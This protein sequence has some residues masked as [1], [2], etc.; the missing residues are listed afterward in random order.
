LETE[1][2]YESETQTEQGRYHEIVSNC[3]PVMLMQ[4]LE[5]QVYE[6]VY[7]LMILV[8][9]QSHQFIIPTYNAPFCD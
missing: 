8:S 4:L 2:F 6:E 1:S 3:K 5:W 9:E 7:F